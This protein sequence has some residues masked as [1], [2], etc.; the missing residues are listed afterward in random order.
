MAEKL[1]KLNKPSFPLSYSDQ[2]GR[3][4]VVASHERSG[5]HFLMNS[6][7][8]NSPYCVENM[9]NFDLF[10]LGDMVNFF[11]QKQ[12]AN[13]FHSVDNAAPGVGELS[14]SS[15]IKSHHSAWFFEDSFKKNDVFFLYIYRDPV[16]TL[17]S[18]WRFIHRWPWLE[19]PKT[20][21]CVEFCRTAPAGQ[22]VRYQHEAA[23]SYFARWA[24][25]VTGWLAAAEAHDNIK[26]VRH[27]SL[28]KNYPSEMASLLEFVGLPPT[29]ALQR[30][31]RDAYI[32]G[33]D[34][35]LTEEDLAETKAYCGDALND[36][37]ALK[38][39]FNH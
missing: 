1:I 6:L 38:A 4:L 34:I 10:P 36:F 18:Y 2:V 35:E 31:A 25:H 17:T 32:K 24:N 29:G 13:F 11:N 19:A 21:S 15:L 14:L 16:E 30:P 37:P 27:D 23:A 22:S 33:A 5:T 28:K 39:L 3:P 26:C 7:A 20:A 9:L 8:A 12:V